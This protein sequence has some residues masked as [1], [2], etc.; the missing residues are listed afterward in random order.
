[1]A[2]GKTYEPI[3]TNTLSSAQTG[4]TFSA[5]SG[6]YTD[7]VL[8]MNVKVTG[9]PGRI[10]IVNFNSDTG[11]NYSHTYLAGNGTAA[12]SGRVTNDTRIAIDA[13]TGIDANNFYPVIMNIQNYS[14]STTYKTCLVR[15]NEASV[16][17]SEVALWRNTNAITSITIT[18]FG[19][20]NENWASGC[21]FTLYGIAAA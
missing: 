21:S 19:L 17:W 16:V 14:N 1:M 13:V 18:A 4:V 6:S 3:A 2:A 12:S 9:S 15:A 8:I 10:P 11:S 7:L 20:I 5:I